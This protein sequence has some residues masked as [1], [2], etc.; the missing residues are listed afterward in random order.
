MHTTTMTPGGGGTPIL[1]LYRDVPS[2]RV[3]FFD[4]PLINRVS[5]W[6]IFEDFFQTGSKNNA[7][8]RKKWVE[9]GLTIINRVSIFQDFLE[10]F[11][12]KQGQG[13]KVRAAPPYPNLGWIPPRD[14]DVWV[15]KYQLVLN[16]ILNVTIRVTENINNLMIPRAKTEIARGSFYYSGPKL[17]KNLPNNIK[18]SLSM[19]ALKE[20]YLK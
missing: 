11:C 4:R 7:F 14:H 5:N 2:F 16:S 12:H 10:N 3:W 17:Y 9:F 1:K 8:W 6:K 20:F 19:S 18:T 15:G 13:F